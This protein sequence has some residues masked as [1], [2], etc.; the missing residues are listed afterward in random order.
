MK[1]KYQLVLQFRGDSLD[2]YDAMMAL[3]DDLIAEFH[4]LAKVDGH[5]MGSG[6]VNIFILTNDPH[7][8][9]QRAKALLER[10]GSLHQGTAAYR[11]IDG[12]DYTVLWPEGSKQEFRVA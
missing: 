1:G 3:E 12:D 11:P 6:E 5:D 8:A 7:A 2:D 9:F 10:R 4:G